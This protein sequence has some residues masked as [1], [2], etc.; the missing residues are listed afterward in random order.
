M[1]SCLNAKASVA[2]A[3]NLV[4]WF[5]LVVSPTVFHHLGLNGVCF[6]KG[7]SEKIKISHVT[8]VLHK[9]A[10]HPISDVTRYLYTHTR[11]IARAQ[12]RW[13]WLRRPRDRHTHTHTHRQRE[14]ERER[15]RERFEK[16]G[17]DAR[18]FF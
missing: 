4:E 14:R 15:E 10:T 1:T 2:R 13:W 18:N 7:R 5:F 11:T 6:S 3:L 8:S 17:E 16:R 12:P 9:N